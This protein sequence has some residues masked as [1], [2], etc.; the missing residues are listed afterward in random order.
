M[1]SYKIVEFGQP[2]AEIEE[3]TPEPQGAEVLLRVTACGVC[4]SDI[5]LWDGYFDLGGGHRVDVSQRGITP[6]HTLG[7]EIAGVV[8][9]VGPQAKGVAV[10]DR[11]M[12]FPWIGC[13]DCARCRAGR[14]HICDSPRFL[15]TRQAGGY[16]DHVLVPDAKYL[17]DPGAVPDELA[18]L[19]TCSGITAF[20][21]LKKVLPLADGHAIL[22]VGC[23]GVGLMGVQLAGAMTGARVIA[24][25]VDAGKLAAA[26]AAGAAETIESG[27][28]RAAASALV[29]A[30]GGGV[31]A[32]ID[33]VGSEASANFALSAVA[34]GGIVVVVGLY[35][36]SL[37]V[38]LV[39]L[40]FR[41]LTIR[42]S[43]VGTL[44]EMQEMW[45]LVRARKLAPVP[46]AT[47]PLDQASA[48][49]ADLKAGRIVGRV[50]L[51]P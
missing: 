39:T 22:M 29:K 26:R 19:Y 31:A 45:D 43:Y 17:F 11:R 16:A 10:G 35:G 44:A 18:C 6:P 21:A 9:A 14:E 41:E 42:G 25:D 51:T 38:P 32:A 23:G 50:A 8:A 1:R 47:R 5:H 3:P 2:L 15:G 20:S 36:G 12:A 24:A 49:L 48:T 13:G 37:T 28:A 4:H 30:T 27:D 33:F 46:V 34:R 7:H 40:P